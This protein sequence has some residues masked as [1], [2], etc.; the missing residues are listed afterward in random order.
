MDNL[1]PL[2]RVPLSTEVDSGHTYHVLKHF[3]A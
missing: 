2:V 1:K 3:G